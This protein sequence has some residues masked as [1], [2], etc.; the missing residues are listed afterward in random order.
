MA[1]ALWDGGGIEVACFMIAG[2]SYGGR[3]IADSSRPVA[4]VSPMWSG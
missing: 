4:P 1:P 2:P 3:A